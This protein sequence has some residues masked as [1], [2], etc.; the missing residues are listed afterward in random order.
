MTYFTILLLT[1][2]HEKT[3]SRC[4]DSIIAQENADLMMECI[5]V[6]DCSTD[7][8]LAVIRRQVGSYKGNISFRIFR[9]QTHH[10]LSRTRNTGLQRAQ[11]YYVMLLNGVDQ[12][13]PGCID[14][15]MVNLMRHWDADVIVGNSYHEG[16]K[17]NLFSQLT[18]A[19]VLRGHGAV[20]AHEMLRSH[21]YLYANNKLVRRDLLTANQIVFDEHLDY[22]DMQWAFAVF[23]SVSSVVLLP[24]I[25]YEYGK[26]ETVSINQAEKNVNALLNSYLATCEH[27][28]DESPRPVDDD[29]GYYHDYQ[30]FVYAVLAHAENM[31]QE[32]AV[33]SQVKRG[34]SAIRSRLL[35]QTKNDGQKMLYLF[36]KQEGS[37][38]SGL[39]K[40]P[41]FSKYRQTIDNIV[42]LL[43]VLVGR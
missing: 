35:T 15:Y 24:D 7:D 6:D 36:F 33:N 13:R 14:T 32:Y 4:L 42:A 31:C 25:T 5:I 29:G 30:L 11:G 34:L 19:L 43:N 22:S 40:T 17:R 37:I 21:L 3:I 41:A 27:L 9:H 2:N 23:T 26:R 39:F 18:S 16:I 1:Y 12:L 38:L 10:G 28:L 20:V 8:T